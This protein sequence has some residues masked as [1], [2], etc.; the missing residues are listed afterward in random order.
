M[1]M[2]SGAAAF[3]ISESSYRVGAS[4]KDAM[5]HLTGGVSV[6]TAGEGDARTGLTVTTAHSLSMD[7]A[8]M[9][10][11]VNRSSSGYGVISAH[12]HFCVNVLGDDQ[13]AVAERF[14]GIGGI[15]G[16]DRYQGESWTQLETGALALNGALAN[17]DCEVT[18][19]ID[20]YSH[21]LFIGLVKAVRVSALRRPQLV[22]QHGAYG[23]YPQLAENHSESG[24]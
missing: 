17:I 15:K 1:N 23:A 22:Y 12:G 9:I 18:D 7:P 19:A 20:R 14:S 3:K 16:K 24:A 13:K 10:I 8:L 11:S 4:L 6:I 21:G 2:I 5:R